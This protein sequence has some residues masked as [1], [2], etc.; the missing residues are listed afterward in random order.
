MAGP[1]K[2]VIYVYRGLGA[3]EEN[4][5]VLMSQLL[6]FANTQIHSVQFIS[7][8]ETIEGECKRQCVNHLISE[9]IVSNFMSRLLMEVCCFL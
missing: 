5:K 8:E 3:L 9:H 2:R 6:R 1:A 4:N 7:P